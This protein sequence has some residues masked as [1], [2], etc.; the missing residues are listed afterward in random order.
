MRLFALVLVLAGCGERGTAV[1]VRADFDTAMSLQQLRFSGERWF[2]PEVRPGAAEGVLQSG[3]ELLVW[4]PDD[5]SGDVRCVV[6]GLVGGKVVA[7]GETRVRLVPGRE[8]PAVVT[9]A[10]MAPGKGPGR[11]GRCDD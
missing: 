7:R 3:G 10:C 4:L 9:L 6:E 8:V 2:G 1:R 5:A 11:L